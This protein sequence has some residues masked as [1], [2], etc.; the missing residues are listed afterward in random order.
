MTSAPSRHTARGPLSRMPTWANRNFQL[1]VSASFISGLGNSGATIAAAY[2]VIDDGGSAT[3][4]GVVAAARTLAMVVFLLI[5]GAVADR[6]PRQRVMVAANGLNAL[7]QGLFALTVLTGHPQLW[8]M[9][10]LTAAG[11]TAQAFFSP[12]SQGLVMTTVDPAHAGKAFSVFRLATN[13]ANIGGAALGGALIAAVG[14][15]WVLAVDAVGFVV[16][17]ALRALMSVEE[18]ARAETGGIVRDL[19]EGWREFVSRSWL[20]G[21]VVQ[22]SIVNAMTTAGEAVY[23]PLVARDHLGGAGPWGLALAAGGAGTVAGGLLMMR[24]RPRRIL[25]TGTLGVFPLALPLVA[26]ALAL[27]LWALVLT[28]LASGV[29]IEVFGVGWMLAL[30]QEIPED[31]MS[32]VSAYDWLGSIAVMP[33]GLALAG[34]AAAAFGRTESL[35]GSAVLVVALTAAVLVLPDVRRLE[36]ANTVPDSGGDDAGHGQAAPLQPAVPLSPQ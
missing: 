1:L 36:R 31:K 5:G 33:L 23:G 13:G 17:G 12:A 28:M 2:A 3:D 6:I 25:L 20:W 24:W 29:A 32:R 7:S 11:G 9:A 30:H 18:A 14:P 19:R 22:F 26:L 21:I 4:V 15:G 35:W 16:A 27:P 8:Q 34:P 10:A